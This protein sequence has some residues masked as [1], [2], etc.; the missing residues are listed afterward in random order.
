MIEIKPS[1]A[2]CFACPACSS[3]NVAVNET[4][5]QAF[6]V[7][8]DCSCTSCGNEFYQTYPIGHTINSQ[9]SIGKLKALHLNGQSKS[10]FYQAFLKAHASTRQVNVPIEKIIYRS[11]E[12]IILL[13]A[14]DFLYG[15]VLLKLY[16]AQYHLDH[17]RDLGLV[18]L[19]PKSFQW[20]I[21]AGCA[22]AWLVNLQLHELTC[23]Y[24]AIQRF[25]SGQFTR[26][27]KIFLSRT[28]SHPD[29]TTID[30]IRFA[31]VNPFN[32]DS[33]T[34]RKPTITFVLREDRCWTAHSGYY[35]L[36]RLCRKF[37]RA[38]WSYR[39][40]AQN[41]NNL[42]KKTIR[43]IRLQL[44]E[45]DFFIVG[46]GGTGNFRGYAIDQRTTTINTSTEKEWCHIYAQSHV[47]IGVHGSNMLLPTALA[48]GCV[49][50]LP[51]ERH[52]NLVQDISVR[53]ND[54]K[55]LFFYRFADEHATTKSVADKAIA[56]IR[57]FADFDRNM[58]RNI[59]PPQ[60]SVRAITR[61]NS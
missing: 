36:Y 54:R 49:E 61:H 4:I 11:C 8:A 55:Q 47:V 41:Q 43:R 40:M 16:N 44:K 1:P 24:E 38:Q 19:L 34:S 53:Y 45:V 14:L 17:H 57:D 23:R 7:E 3:V 39:L 20:L 25:V 28:Y 35:W 48:A 42:V 18:I 52:P 26:F 59:Y 46:L 5:A 6:Y 2:N 9:V 10:W 37:N 56:I 22:E 13:N 50:I 58:C 21:P 60:K 31:K 51:D 15:H 32:L 30:I 27:K 12:N 29:F 33:F